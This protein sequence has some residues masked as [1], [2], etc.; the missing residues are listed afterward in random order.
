MD[1]VQKLNNC[2]MKKK[3]GRALEYLL[4]VFFLTE[5][6]LIQGISLF[7]G[8]SAQMKVAQNPAQ[9]IHQSKSL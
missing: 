4:V 7:Y 2:I 3:N 9:N 5:P 1:N 6:E 8:N